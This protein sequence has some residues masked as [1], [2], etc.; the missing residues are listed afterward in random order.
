MANILLLLMIF[1]F[2]FAVIGVS[3][4]ANISPKYFGNLET[5]IL[6]LLE[7]AVAELKICITRVMP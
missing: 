2:V 4:F 7:R 3:L 6:L 5:S 1:M